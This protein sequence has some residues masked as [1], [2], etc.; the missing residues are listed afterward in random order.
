[1]YTSSLSGSLKHLRFAEGVDSALSVVLDTIVT[2]RENGSCVWTTAEAGNR[3]G[4]TCYWPGVSG[5]DAH[6]TSALLLDA[7]L[8]TQMP[9][10]NN[11]WARR[12]RL[13]GRGN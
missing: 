6:N 5:A 9:V 10:V 11:K 1:M 12:C 3:P 13:R 8:T 2:K 7:G 4:P